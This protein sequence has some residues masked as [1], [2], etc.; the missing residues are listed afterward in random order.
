MDVDMARRP[1]P[2]WLYRDDRPA[3]FAA[4]GMIPNTGLADYDLWRQKLDERLAV[5]SIADLRTGREMA[6]TLAET[7]AR[8]P[9]GV[10][11]IRSGALLYGN[12]IYGQCTPVADHPYQGIEELWV[13]S[14]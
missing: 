4:L 9:F 14:G 7:A 8:S 1:D 3:A 2:G 5:S 6:D 10:L 11:L 12:R 13:W